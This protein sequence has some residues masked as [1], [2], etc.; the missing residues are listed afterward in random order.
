[1]KNIE[2]ELSRIKKGFENRDRI[3]E[4]YKTCLSLIDLTTL[5]S[6]D[7]PSKV[8]GMIEKVNGFHMIYP[9]YPS[10][11]AIC[12][13][14][15]FAGQVRSQLRIDGVKIAVVAG[16]FPSSQSFPEIKIAECRMAV[17]NGADE[18][19]I[20]LAL[21]KFLDNDKDGAFKE[22]KSIK[23]AI[24][25]KH[26]KV[27]LETGALKNYDKIAEASS[28]AIEAGADF[29]KTSTG[30]MEPAATPEAAYIMCNKIKEHYNKTGKRVGFKPAGG[31][32]TPG[33]ASLYYAIVEDILG[34]DWLNPQLFRIGA[35]RLANNLL[36]E[37]EGKT[38]NYF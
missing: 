2:N 28:L 9:S 26:L 23:E 36:T 38:I 24:G 4:I 21:S 34:K 20:V 15:N 7:T 5:N 32:S 1:M 16:V 19:D 17:E 14:P 22:I 13:Y 18:V 31:I 11:A 25:N 6:T 29:I 35:S 3:S 8:A 12:V 30:K 10:V 37:I 27:I 33:E